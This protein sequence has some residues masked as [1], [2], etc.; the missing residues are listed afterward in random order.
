MSGFGHIEQC[1]SCRAPIYWALTDKG[2]TMPVDAF[3][4][5]DR[6][7]VALHED[8]GKLRAVVVPRAKAEAMRAAGHNLHTS[9]FASCPKADAHRKNKPGRPVG[10]R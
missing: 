4:D 10:N 5:P 7:N 6:G 1:G 9:H 2:K 3:P 8:R